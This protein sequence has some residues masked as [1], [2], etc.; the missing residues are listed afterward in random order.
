MP[1]A[2]AV[3][4]IIGGA[5]SIGGALIGSSASSKAAAQ[6]AAAYQQA[7]KQI[8]DAIA[9]GQANVGNNVGIANSILGNGLSLYQPY[10]QAGTNSISAIQNLAGA[11]GPL[12]QQFSFNPTDLQNDP[13]YQF[14]LQQGQQAIQRAA[15]AKGN[16]F[17]SGTLKSLAGYTTGTANQYFNDAFNRAQSTFN[18]NRQGALAQIGTLQGLAGMG[19]QGVGGTQNIYGQQAANS[20]QGAEFGSNLGVQGAEALI[21]PITGQGNANAAGTIGGANAWSSALSGIGGIANNYGNLAMLKQMMQAQ[22]TGGGPVASG[23]PFGSYGPTL[24]QLGI[25]ATPSGDDAGGF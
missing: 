13:G 4:A 10:I 19:M 22:P 9:G 2:A 7:Q 6:Q 20:L 1:I 24:S 18:T 21:G 11:N 14:T 25:G 17:S 12:A 8:S 23:M 16:L 5:A 3:P 15:A